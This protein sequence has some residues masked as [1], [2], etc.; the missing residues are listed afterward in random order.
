MK[1][2]SIFLNIKPQYAIFFIFSLTIWK[3][4]CKD[5]LNNKIKKYCSKADSSIKSY[6]EERQELPEK[7]KNLEFKDEISENELNSSIKLLLIDEENRNNFMQSK[8][9]EKKYIHIIIKIIMI[10]LTIFVLDFEIHFFLRFCFKKD[11]LNPSFTNFYK[12]SPFYWIFYF[13]LNKQKTIELYYNFLNK[14]INKINKYIYFIISFIIFVV[15]IVI[16]IITFMNCNEYK[17]STQ[18][19]N[20]VLCSSINL[21]NEIQN[22]KQLKKDGTHLIGLKEI[23][24]F[25]NE[26]TENKNLFKNYFNNYTETKNEININLNEWENFLIDIQTNLSDKNTLKYFFVN[27]PSDPSYINKI[28]CYFNKPETCKKILF[29]TEIIYNYYPYDD[30]SKTLW[31]FNNNLIKNIENLF[32]KLKIFEQFFIE[33]ENSVKS[34]FENQN[35]KNALIKIEYIINIYTKQLLEIDKEKI[36]D[37]F[38]NTYLSYIYTFDYILLILLGINCFLTF[39]YVEYYCI[40]KFIFIRVIISFIFCNINFIILYFS[41]NETNKLKNININFLYFKEISKAIYYILNDEMKNYK[42]LFNE[43]NNSH[44][45]DISLVMQFKNSEMNNNLFNYIIY[46]IN[47]ENELKKLLYDKILRINTNQL[48]IINDTLSDVIDNKNNLT[49]LNTQINNFSEKIFKLIKEGLTFS[50]NFYDLIHKG[51][52]ETYLESPLTYLTYVNLL[53]RNNTRKQ[54]KIYGIT[55]DETWNISTSDYYEYTYVPRSEVLCE[56]CKNICSDGKILLN[57]MEYSI[58]EIEQRYNHL[59][60]GTFSNIYYELMYYFNATEQLRDEK[61]FEQL[62][63][64]YEMNENLKIFL[65]NI[66]NSVEKLEYITKKT[67]SIYEN[68]VN[69]YEN[70][71]ITFNYTEFIKDDLYYLL[72]QIE[73]NF[74]KKITKEYKDHLNINIMCIC[75]CLSLIIYYILIAKEIKYYKKDKNEEDESNKSVK[76]HVIQNCIKI[77][78][79]N[80][81]NGH[82]NPRFKNIINTYIINKS[83]NRKTNKNL[84]KINSN[85]IDTNKNKNANEN[86]NVK[87]IELL[88]A[89]KILINEELKKSIMP[90]T[91]IDESRNNESRLG[92]S[93]DLII[94]NK[95][96]NVL[97]NNN[98]DSHK[99]L[100]S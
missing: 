42:N 74:S 36:F 71:N 18:V 46:Y 90:S 64:F 1:H 93:K 45:R 84:K 100:N 13:I 8:H 55:C 2:F 61:I 95:K 17:N 51:F 56:N 78:Q 73:I 68:I 63:D 58:D 77:D 44:F 40:K 4:N 88:N 66:F 14:S 22:G 62:E 3:M 12:I 37:K 5:T 76:Q 97:K 10:I 48:R 32:E 11:I 75:I 54:K 72:G 59:K 80:I 83:K 30:K 65:K 57:F 60:N 99:Q 33:S 43:E 87:K 19:T 26:L 16:F 35:L 52:H 96:E 81:G 29:Q 31:T 70:K 79:I 92:L 9:N 85:D 41:F 91:Q 53:S 15:I 6:F 94:E 38:I 39:I 49:V 20:N 86:F 23:N 28:S 25:L 50:T 67:I 24:S 82:G 27:Y 7:F 89:K 98:N 47:N 69:K 21:L 34:F